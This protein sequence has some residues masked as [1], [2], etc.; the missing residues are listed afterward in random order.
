MQLTYCLTLTVLEK[1][2]SELKAKNPTAVI[3]P[4]CSKIM[5]Q[6]ACNCGIGIE[7]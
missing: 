2:A 4:Y 6:E 5:E 1:L 7:Q 3:C